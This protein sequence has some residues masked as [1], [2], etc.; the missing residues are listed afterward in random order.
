MG[1]LYMIRH[2]QASFGTENYDR[3]SPTGIRQADILAAHIERCKITANIFYSG[4]MK[5]QIDTASPA[6]LRSRQKNPGSPGL[7]I[8]G[9]F[10]EYSSQDLMVTFARK[11]AVDDFGEDIETI[12]GDRKKFQRLFERILSGWANGTYKKDGLATW[13]E[14]ASRVWDGMKRI[15]T[16]HPSGKTVVIFTSGGPISAMVQKSLKLSNDSAIRLGWQI[17]NAS[18]TKF[19][20]NRENFTLSTFNETTHLL[21]EG[22]PGLITYR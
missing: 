13:E 6:V 3:L 5:R 20:Y 2:G 11:I 21:L 9:S 16:E 19:L 8:D 10:N 7:T 15:M 17:A 4:E 18:L 12:Y 22:D 1:T 14:F